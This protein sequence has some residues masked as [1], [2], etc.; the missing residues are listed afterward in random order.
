MHNRQMAGLCIATAMICGGGVVGIAAKTKGSSTDKVE[1]VRLAGK[2]VYRLPRGSTLEGDPVPSP[3]GDAT[4]F[5]ERHGEELALIVCIKGADPARWDLPPEARAYRIFWIEKQRV[6]LG[7]T[8]FQPRLA[9]SW[10]VS[11]E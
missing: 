9:V 8:Q 1:L 7:P 4:A 10:H 2:V 5:L 6:I 3:V 11:Y